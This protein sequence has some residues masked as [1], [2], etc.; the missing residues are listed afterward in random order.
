MNWRRIFSLIL[1]ILMVS[2]LGLVSWQNQFTRD[3]NAW[4]KATPT[5]NSK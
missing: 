5:V 2:I 4:L 1:M 3:Y